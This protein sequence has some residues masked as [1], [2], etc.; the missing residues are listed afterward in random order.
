L[1]VVPSCEAPRWTPWY[2]LGYLSKNR[3]DRTVG[4]WG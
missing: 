1:K 2:I 4:C 3:G